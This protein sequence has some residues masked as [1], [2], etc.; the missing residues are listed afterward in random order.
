MVSIIEEFES[1]IKS[2]KNDLLIKMNELQNKLFTDQNID[3][4]LNEYITFQK[5][6]DNIFY[7]SNIFKQTLT[8]IMI[9]YEVSNIRNHL[10][11]ISPGLFKRILQIK[12]KDIIY[13]GATSITIKEWIEEYFDTIICEKDIKFLNTKLQELSVN[14]PSII[15]TSDRELII[16]NIL[17]KH[18]QKSRLDDIN[19]KSIQLKAV[20]LLR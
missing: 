10:S 6:F 8:F 2:I 7:L 20:N 19:K 14:C 9:M 11:K 17:I 12:V 15:S 1:E 3:N 4:N 5:D 16:A 18:S 13:N